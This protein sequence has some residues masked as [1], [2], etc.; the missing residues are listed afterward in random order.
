MPV[1]YDVTMDQLAAFGDELLDI[2]CPP[3]TEEN[4][5]KV[6]CDIAAFIQKL[7]NLEH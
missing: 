6:S 2:K 4:V 1:S 7:S 5:V 3:V